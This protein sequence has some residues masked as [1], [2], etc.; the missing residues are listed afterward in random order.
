[1]SI[2]KCTRPAAVAMAAA[3]LGCPSSGGKVSADR[4][5]PEET[6]AVKQC[7]PAILQVERRVEMKVL[8]EWMTA[9]LY[10]AGCRSDL[11]KL[12]PEQRAAAVAFFKEHTAADPRGHFRNCE[13]RGSVAAPDAALL[14]GLNQRLGQ[15]RVSDWCLDVLAISGAM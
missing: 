7:A 8:S 9:S 11:E 12:G 6:T 10:V 4:S 13:S 1:M 15:A 14:A 2:G 5:G 3:L